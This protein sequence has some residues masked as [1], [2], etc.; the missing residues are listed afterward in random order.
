MREEQEEYARDL[1]ADAQRCL[2]LAQRMAHS[3]GIEATIVARKG[4]VYEEI[5]AA[6]R[7]YHIGLLIVGEVTCV[8]SRREEI[9]D[10]TERAIRLAGCSVL[11]VRDRTRVD[12]FF[13]ALQ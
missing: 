13:D 4:G 6:V 11:I 12:R 7:R 1:E 10:D 3:K 5:V 8:R 9:Y 2:G